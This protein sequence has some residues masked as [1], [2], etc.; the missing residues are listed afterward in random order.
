[1]VFCIVALVVFGFLGIFSAKYRTYFKESLHCLKRTV[2]LKPCDTEFDRRL[3]AKITAGLMKRSEKLGKFVYNK[4]TMI[5]WILLLAMIISSIFSAISIYNLMIYGN[6]NGPEST[7]ICGLNPEGTSGVGSINQLNSSEVTLDGPS[8][9][10]GNITIVEFGCYSCPYTKKAEPI[11][12]EVL[13]KYNGKVRLV[14][15]NFPIERHSLSM[16]EAIAAKCVYTQ[17]NESY[18]VYRDSLFENQKD[19]TEQTIVDLTKNLQI[20]QTLFN[21]CFDNNQTID[22]VNREYE[23]GKLAGVFGTPTFFIGNITIIGPKPFSDF[24]KAI[25]GQEVINQEINSCTDK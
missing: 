9:G 2:M 20:N 1:M 15:K 19:M 23:N 7:D 21:Q 24:E 12:K 6:C 10:T 11:V 13:Q 14:F 8:I 22:E 17:D 5:A 3:K 18:W 16:S 4:F 25:K